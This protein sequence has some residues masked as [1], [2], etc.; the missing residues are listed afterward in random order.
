MSLSY[1]Q[2][3]DGVSP[4]STP[5]GWIFDSPWVTSTNG[6]PYSSPNQLSLTGAVANTKYLGTYQ[7]G[8]GSG[9]NPT[10]ATC[11]AWCKLSLPPVLPF[12]NDHYQGGIAF[13]GSASTLNTSST[14]FYLLYFDINQGIGTGLIRFSKMVSGTL[15]NL[16]SVDGSLTNSVF[17]FIQ[18]VLTWNG[19]ANSISCY[20]QRDTDNYWMDG[21][22]VWQSSQIAT[23]TSSDSSITSGEY[24]GVWGASPTGK[25]IWIDD[26]SINSNPSA[27]GA[28]GNRRP[29]DGMKFFSDMTGGIRG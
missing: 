2:N 4:P 16:A 24:F 17:Y 12:G 21:S 15:T 8:D 25:N 10:T 20:V 29:L 3:F 9:S 6:V 19:S 28:G 13:R 22:G 7:T 26:F 18:A 5:A 14:T 11:S 27:G 23:I 1:T